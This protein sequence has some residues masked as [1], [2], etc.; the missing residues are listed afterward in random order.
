MYKIKF[1]TQF[2]R[3]LPVVLSKFFSIALLFLSLWLTS[4]NAHANVCLDL[5]TGQDPLL[6]N[7]RAGTAA[8]TTV[9][10]AVSPNGKSEWVQVHHQSLKDEYGKPLL[11]FEAHLE[12][13]T[14]KM[15][16]SVLSRNESTKE[17]FD[18]EV[19]AQSLFW[20]AVNRLGKDRINIIVGDWEMGKYKFYDPTI[21]YSSNTGMFYA[22]LGK[23]MT[24]IEAAKDTWTG[25]LAVAMGL[26]NV[27]I[28]GIEETPSRRSFNVH[29][30]RTP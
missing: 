22:N 21:P 16:F 5:F 19:F 12:K 1:K 15:N 30:Y 13:A 4:I 10:H 7:V 26:K 29:F 3:A 23:G 18:P 25:R 14:G 17:H 27:E 6:Q 2:K 28:L 20:L 8:R 11:L 9:T 24:P